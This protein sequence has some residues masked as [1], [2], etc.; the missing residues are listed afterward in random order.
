MSS[1]AEA[2]IRIVKA[3]IPPWY[4]DLSNALDGVKGLCRQVGRFPVM[5]LSHEGLAPSGI[6][7]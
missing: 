1:I 4:W 7:E 5:C 2:L 3:A 6:R